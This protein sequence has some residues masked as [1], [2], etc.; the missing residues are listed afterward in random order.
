MMLETD[1]NWKKLG[2][3]AIVQEIGKALR[4]VRLRMNLTQD[5]V[6]ERAGLDRTTVVQLEKGRSA[7]LLTLIQILRVLEKLDALSGFQEESR[8]SP[9]EMVKMMAKTRKRASRTHRKPNR[10]KP[11]W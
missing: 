8:M 5:E 4:A 2:N 11:Q 9:I 7:S 3:E 10:K 6:A 1:I